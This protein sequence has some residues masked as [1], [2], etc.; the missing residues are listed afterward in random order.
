M[1]LKPSSYIIASL[2][3]NDRSSFLCYSRISADRCES[4]LSGLQ[5]DFYRQKS[6]IIDKFR[7]GVR[8]NGL[9][10]S[11]ARRSPSSR[12]LL[13][14]QFLELF[15]A[16]KFPET[17]NIPVLR[18]FSAIAF[19]E[20]IIFRLLSTFLTILVPGNS[21]FK[22]YWNRASEKGG[23]NPLNHDFWE[24]PLLFSEDP[25]SL[26]P[27]TQSREN[28]RFPP[29]SS[30]TPG[31]PNNYATDLPAARNPPASPSTVPTAP[32]SGPYLPM[33]NG[34]PHGLPSASGYKHI[35]LTA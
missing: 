4:I 2:S 30:I 15:N 22:D 5:E 32:R 1:L 26:M 27:L 7:Q 29:R 14:L 20:A 17:N 21:I 19:P 31:G 12:K 35:V 18:T 8:L 6:T 24:P 25:V 10:H 28:P 3:S 33:T 11:E 34:R 9:F 16:R 23:H 13:F